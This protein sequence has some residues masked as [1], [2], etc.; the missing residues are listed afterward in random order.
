MHFNSNNFFSS[1]NNYLIGFADGSKPLATYL[2]DSP[3]SYGIVAKNY[4]C[5]CWLWGEE[6]EHELDHPIGSISAGDV[7]GS[8]LML[9]SKNELAIF[10]TFNGILLGK[11]F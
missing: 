1:E 2:G 8:G 11:L 9:N 3:N 5:W 7:F 10:F 6:H 4:V